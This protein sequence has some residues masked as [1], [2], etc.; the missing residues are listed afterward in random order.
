MLKK[1][2]LLSYIILCYG[3]VIAVPDTN[4]VSHQEYVT[5]LKTTLAHLNI[6]KATLVQS[7]DL[8]LGK[9]LLSLSPMILH[10]AL[11]SINNWGNLGTEKDVCIISYGC[12][13]LLTL[14]LLIRVIRLVYVFS[15]IE[16]IEN[17]L[18]KYEDNKP[19]ILIINQIRI[20]NQ[21]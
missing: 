6:E 17:E 21:A 16:A 19:E 11:K 14:H 7:F 8:N 9:F 12:S 5:A 3:E 13:L 20:N 18:A 2:T 10:M 1:I 4:Y 15:D